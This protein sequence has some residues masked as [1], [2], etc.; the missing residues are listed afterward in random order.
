MRTTYLIALFILLL[1]ATAFAIPPQNQNCAK[2]DVWTGNT[3]DG[4]ALLPRSCTY[5]GQDGTPTPGIVR[6][7]PAGT[8]IAAVLATA[9]CGDVLELT[10]GASYGAFTAPNK[11]CDARHWIQ[12]RVATPDMNLPAPGSR[13]NPSYA[14]VASLP[15]RPP[16]SGGTSN[17]MAKIST[18]AESMPPPA[19]TFAKGA[20]HY[21]IGPGLELSRPEGIGRVT[22]LI[23][24]ANTDHIIVDRNW[25][26]GSSL[27]EETTR[28]V[29]LSGATHFA[30]TG[31]YAND[32]KCLANIGHCADSQVLAGGDGL[33][34]HPEFAWTIY[35]NFLE[36]AGEN[37]MIGG[38]NP[39]NQVPTDLYIFANHFY[40][41]PSWQQCAVT[42]YVVK[43]DF[44]MKNGSYAL[45]EDNL[46]EYS[47]GGY[48]QTGNAFLL[49]VRG[50]WAHVENVTLRYN[51]IS[52]V[53]STMELSATRTCHS[54]GAPG[55]I[56]P[57]FW[58]DSGGAGSYSI[59]D[60]LFDDVSET[61]YY[62]NATTLV[63]SA[64]QTHPPLHNVEL[65][66]VTIV[67]NNQE[68]N[69]FF[70]GTNVSNPQ[71]KM[72]PFVLTNSILF[73]GKYGGIWNVGP[74]FRCV[75]NQKP[76]A[77]F[78]RC[79]TSQTVSGNLVIGWNPLIWGAWPAGNHYPAEPA[80][81]F[82]NYQ[83]YDGDYHV[84]FPYARTAT[85]GRDPGADIDG[86]TAA[87][88]G[89]E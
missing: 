1:G 40:K 70:L 9:N 13:I 47:W 12:I 32:F 17:V 14:G 27:V 63:D 33:L 35:N 29:F 51:H 44:E 89:V 66:H 31:N 87:L 50:S 60:L 20:N 54:S 15:D 67:T 48:T 83:T 25:C 79:F 56:C 28:C 77:S 3:S 76:L 53:G 37:I 61:A 36:A 55:N 42:C 38:G 11:S 41:P 86:L 18:D 49:T 57:T 4:P 84:I 65:N 81:V 64:F 10:P 24:A 69:I 62:G 16:F 58:Q 85:D 23:Q 71:P 30:F 19:I 26:H 8:S 80:S 82:K 6:P 46:I 43:N 75:A 22:M 2:G 68:G 88:A 73:A 52:H 74:A 34:T 72:G 5:M 45:V 7:V 59:H 39:G 21:I 78:N